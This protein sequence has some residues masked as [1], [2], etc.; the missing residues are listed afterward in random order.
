METLLL[1]A[2]ASQFF[3]HSQAVLD[4]PI[5]AVFAQRLKLGEATHTRMT[6]QLAFFVSPTLTSVRQA[7]ITSRKP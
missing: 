4:F 1:L 6:F 5:N 3:V 2:R 7:I